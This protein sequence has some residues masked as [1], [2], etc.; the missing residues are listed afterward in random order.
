MEYKSLTGGIISLALIATIL[1]GF[2][3]MIILTLQ[4]EQIS[5]N[6]TVEKH[7]DPTYMSV[8]MN[9]ESKFMIGF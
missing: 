3:N 1:V 4:R 6:K 5:S 9:P 7:S 8:K 2:A